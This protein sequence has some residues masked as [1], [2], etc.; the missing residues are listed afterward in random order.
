MYSAHGI[1]PA[2]HDEAGQRGLQVVDA[3]CP[4]V[5]KVHLEAIRFARLGYSIVLVGH[6]D[7]D[8]VVGTLGEAPEQMTLVET[9]DDVDRLR[10]AGSGQSGLPHANDAQR[11]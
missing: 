7:H 11:R 10:G 2:V 4:L 8:E 6:R 3:T 1:S 9:V 5:R